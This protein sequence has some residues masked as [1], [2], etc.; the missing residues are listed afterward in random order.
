MIIAPITES[1]HRRDKE[2]TLPNDDSNN[3]EAAKT[4]WNVVRRKILREHETVTFDTLE[5]IAE[6]AKHRARETV[7][8]DIELLRANNRKEEQARQTRIAAKKRDSI[9]EGR[10]LSPRKPSMRRLTPFPM[11]HS[12]NH[13]VPHHIKTHI[14]TTVSAF[15]FPRQRMAMQVGHISI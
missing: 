12:S 6:T 9:D 10:A 2:N 5:L 8:Q 13:T 11:H 1:S 4:L 15:P 14:S 3:N 7:M